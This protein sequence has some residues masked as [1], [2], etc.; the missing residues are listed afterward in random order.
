MAG[1]MQ[2]RDAMMMMYNNA[3]QKADG[4]RQV[5]REHHTL[6]TGGDTN[7]YNGAWNVD[8]NANASDASIKHDVM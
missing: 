8:E 2:Q 3:R 1:G 7:E 4:M 5:N 6:D